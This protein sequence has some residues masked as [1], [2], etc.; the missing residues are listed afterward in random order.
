MSKPMEKIVFEQRSKCPYCSKLIHTKVTRVTV[1][2]SIPGSFKTVGIIEK[3]PQSTLEEDYQ[4]SIKKG[5]KMVER[6]AF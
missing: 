4:T 5:K 1:C 6:K 2:A 3:D